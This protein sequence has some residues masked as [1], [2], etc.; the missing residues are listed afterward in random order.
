MVWIGSWTSQCTCS[1]GYTAGARK[2]RGGPG[3]RVHICV[4]LGMDTR[5]TGM[6][7]VLLLAPV[8]SVRLVLPLASRRSP[9]TSC[10]VDTGDDAIA[11]D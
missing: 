5:S 3:Q 7:L 11:E 9:E 6:K 2:F 8:I 1:L 10:R 4:V